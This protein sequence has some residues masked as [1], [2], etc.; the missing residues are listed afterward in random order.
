M[1]LKKASKKA[2]IYSC[3]NFHYSKT[4]PAGATYGYSVFNKKK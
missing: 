3:T 1:I 4:R 2:I